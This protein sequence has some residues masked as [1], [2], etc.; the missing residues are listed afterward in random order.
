MVLRPRLRSISSALPC[1]CTCPVSSP[2]SRSLGQKKGK[3]KWQNGADAK[4]QHRPGL[5]GALW[6]TCLGI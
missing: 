2:L 3:S 5:A 4:S 1:E 6:R